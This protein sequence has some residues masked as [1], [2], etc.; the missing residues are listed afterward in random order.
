MNGKSTPP[1]APAGVP[2]DM[3]MPEFIMACA[4][5][6]IGSLIVLASVD[7]LTGGQLTGLVLSLGSKA[8]SQVPGLLHAVDG[9]GDEHA[10]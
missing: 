6:L 1:A 8:R 10:A 2:Y 4:G 3:K 5:V 7:L 9:K